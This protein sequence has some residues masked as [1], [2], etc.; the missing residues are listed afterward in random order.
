MVTRGRN[1]VRRSLV[2]CTGGG[3]RSAPFEFSVQVDAGQP[4]VVHRV[5]GPLDTWGLA[6]GQAQVGERRRQE[7]EAVSDD[8]PDPAAERQRRTSPRGERHT[9]PGAS[10]PTALDASPILIPDRSSRAGS[11]HSEL[12]SAGDP[13]GCPSSSGR[14]STPG[15]HSQRPRRQSSRTSARRLITALAAPSRP[16]GPESRCRRDQVV[17]KRIRRIDPLQHPYVAMEVCQLV[18]ET[19]VEVPRDR[20]S[21]LGVGTTPSRPGTPSSRPCWPTRP[22]RTTR[23]I[24]QAG[25]GPGRDQTARRQVPRDR[26][27]ARRHT[28]AGTGERRGRGDA[29]AGGG[30]A[31]GAR[32]AARDRSKTS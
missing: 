10:R 5:V 7:W 21:L 17:Q 14:C 1:L 18:V 3:T 11:L 25:Q 13:A 24:P 32:G 12:P 23:R 19:R 16:L 2:H 30:G 6:T 29:R 20:L 28:G 8:P 26:S 9:A 31:R 15:I 22:S 4:G 27:V